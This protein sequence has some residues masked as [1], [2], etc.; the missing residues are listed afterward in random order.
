MPARSA[1][2][3]AEIHGN[4]VEGNLWMSDAAVTQAS[5]RIKIATESYPT[6]HKLLD[7]V[8]KRLKDALG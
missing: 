8:E 1:A 2:H 3:A 7:R 4:K 6:L 5:L